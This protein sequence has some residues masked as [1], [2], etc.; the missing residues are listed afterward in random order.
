MT[1]KEQIGNRERQEAQRAET[2][3]LSNG[4]KGSRA[5]VI[6]VKPY[7]FFPYCYAFLD[8]G[9]LRFEG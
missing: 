8:T 2:K 7:Y 4:V 3:C 5:F 1:M 6:A 9:C